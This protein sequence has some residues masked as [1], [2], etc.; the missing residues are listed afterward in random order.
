L[1]EA[2]AAYEEAIK[3]TT[4]LDNKRTLAVIKFQLGTVRLLQQRYADALKACAEARD[5]FAGMG[6]SGSVAGVWHQI[7]MAH[8][9]A[10]D[11]EAAEQA[12]RQSLAIKVQ[13]KDYAGE[14]SSLLE[15]GNLYYA[16]GR[17]E[18]SA[19]FTRQAADIY[20]TLQDLAKEG[21]A[22]N[23]LAD[24]L[25]KLQRYD[26]ARRELLRAIECRQPY[27][28]AAQLWKTWSILYDLEQ[29]TGNPQAAALARQQALQSYLA[30]RRDGGENQSAGA[31]W[32]AATLQAIQQGTAN[33]ALEELARLLTPDASDRAKALILK[34]QAILRGSRDLALA[35]DAA[36]GYQDAAEL[37]LL[38]ERL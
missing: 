16:M 30:Y 23:N 3:R 31:Q 15:L 17:L 7:G 20:G 13:L 36:L 21:L 22:R 27:G 38:L 18:E 29:V 25:I 19:T 10:G 33:K 8:R 11:L 4:K 24:T 28:H 5:T 34:L 1:D 32:C 37:M 35:E 6:E 12:Y 14:G 9:Q 2:A 26:E